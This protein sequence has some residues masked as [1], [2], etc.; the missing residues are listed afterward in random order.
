MSLSEELGKL[1]ELRDRGTLTDEEFKRAKD[2]LLNGE[3]V[4]S[5]EPF[6]PAINS[7]RRSRNDRWIAGVCGGIANRTGLEAW[8]CRLI[9][10]ALFLCGGAGILIYL[11]L[12]IFVP[13][14]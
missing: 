6:V 14:E 4:S 7:L 13:S 2:R 10:T 3:R 5:S 12:W 1:G 8:A 11:L 9:F